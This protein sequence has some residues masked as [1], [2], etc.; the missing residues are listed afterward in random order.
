MQT[1]TAK[2]DSGDSSNSDSDTAVFANDAAAALRMSGDRVAA[3]KDSS[4]LHDD[5]N[6]DND[7]EETKRAEILVATLINLSKTQGAAG[8]LAKLGQE[9]KAVEEENKELK[10]ALALAN[11]HQ[12]RSNAEIDALKSEL[13]YRRRE[14]ERLQEE[15]KAS[16][17]LLRVE[18]EKIR[19]TLA[20]QKEMHEKQTV[21]TI[22]LLND[23]NQTNL[24]LKKDIAALHEQKHAEFE[25]IKNNYN[26]MLSTL[27]LTH[28]LSSLLPSLSLLSLSSLSS[29]SSMIKITVGSCYSYDGKYDM[30]ITPKFIYIYPKNGA[31]FS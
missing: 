3:E 16:A 21:E 12:S 7:M 22:Y 28:P 4:C 27:T 13:D 1:V 14:T 2:R 17:T 31:S 20:E 18:E 5:D 11:E 10:R 25:N 23:M 9:K 19:A 30:F 29:L 26:C 8:K 15:V 6:D 24:E